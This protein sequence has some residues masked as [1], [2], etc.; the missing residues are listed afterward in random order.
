[1]CSWWHWV[2]NETADE[3]GDLSTYQIASDECA[4]LE[5]LCLLF[6][7]TEEGGGGGCGGCTSIQY[8]ALNVVLICIRTSRPEASHTSSHYQEIRGRCQYPAQTT[9]LTGLRAMDRGNKVVS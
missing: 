5:M 3:K 6:E 7:Q 2:A 8:T 1:M 9:G 4:V